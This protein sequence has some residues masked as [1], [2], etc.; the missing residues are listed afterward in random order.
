[1]PPTT[2][3]RN[4]PSGQLKSA[5]AG[6]GGITPPAGQ[7]GGTALLPTVIGITESTGDELD[8]GQI[9][10]GKFLKRVGLDVVGADAASDTDNITNNSSIP[11]GASNTA[12]GAL[13]RLGPVEA[14]DA[15]ALPDASATYT[16]TTRRVMLAST[17]TAARVLTW[18][19]TATA[20]RSFYIDIATQGHQVT[21][22]S[23]GPLG[24]SIVIAAGARLR[25][26]V[27]SDGSNLSFTSE[28]LGSEPLLIAA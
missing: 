13:N 23:G 28:E 9:D 4:S 18:T 22:L 24:N 11:D 8:I 26:A 6:G 3:I 21:I 1:M 14:Q 19:P 25:I 5:G 27:V 2:D 15:T 17:T 12:T 20:L 16:T 10:D 7:I